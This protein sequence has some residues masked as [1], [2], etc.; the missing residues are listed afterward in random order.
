MIKWS[1]TELGRFAWGNILLSLIAHSV[2]CSRA[3]Y[4]PVHPSH[5]VQYNKY[6]VLPNNLVSFNL[7]YSST[8]NRLFFSDF[9]EASGDFH[10]ATI[11]DFKFRKFSVSNRKVFSIQAKSLVFSFNLAI[12]L[13]FQK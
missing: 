4:F 2:P 11:S 8:K 7:V 6:I 9:S 10:L 1:L 3:K 12:S 13:V 5:S